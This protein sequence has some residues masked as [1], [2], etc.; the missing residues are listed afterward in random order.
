MPGRNSD[1]DKRMAAYLKD[2]KVERTTGIC[3]IC[4]KVIPNGAGAVN[5]Y[6]LHG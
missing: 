4:Y 3:C 5:H 2:L 6:R 1:K